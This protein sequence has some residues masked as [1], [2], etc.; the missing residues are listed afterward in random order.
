MPSLREAE[1]ELGKK[2]FSGWG[3]MKSVV[4]DVQN[5]RFPLPAM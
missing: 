5:G 2:G 3:E 1:E 4:Q